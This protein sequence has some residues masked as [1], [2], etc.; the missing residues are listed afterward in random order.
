M[1]TC[2]HASSQ[3]GSAQFLLR[4]D[5][6]SLLLWQTLQKDGIIK[7]IYNVD[8]HTATPP[9]EQTQEEV[10]WLV[11]F[12]VMMSHT[13]RNLCRSTSY[14]FFFWK[15]MIGRKQEVRL[16]FTQ[17][18]GD[19]RCGGTDLLA[20]LLEHVL[21]FLRHHLPLFAAEHHALG[22]GHVLHVDHQLGAVQRVA[23]TGQKH[24]A[25][26]QP[27]KRCRGATGQ[28]AAMLACGWLA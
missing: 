14:C 4:H 9:A 25:V 8:T 23:V 28:C 26:S 19:R 10:G 1:R 5:A 6:V 17:R 20:A 7:Q 24:T 2:G 11:G 3:F 12:W 18:R 15:K 13:S 21:L 22:A 16:A 27:S